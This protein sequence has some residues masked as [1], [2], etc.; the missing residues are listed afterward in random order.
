M[1]KLLIVPDYDPN[2]GIEYSWKDGF[3][4]KVE[5]LDG[6]VLISANAEGLTSLAMHL[7]FLAQNSVPSGSH[8]HYD[9]CNSLKEGSASLVVEKIY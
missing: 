9:D 7:L 5:V 4:L 1:E 6:S 3:I 2:R 8:M